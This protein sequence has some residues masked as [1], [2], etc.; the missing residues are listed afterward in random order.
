MEFSAIL[1]LALVNSLSSFSH[2]Y[3][4][5]SLNDLSILPQRNHQL[6]CFVLF[7]WQWIIFIV[8]TLIIQFPC[9][10]LMLKRHT[11]GNPPHRNGYL[12]RNRNSEE[13]NWCEHTQWRQPDKNNPA[14][15]ALLTVT[16][17][18][19]YSKEAPAVAEDLQVVTTLKV[20]TINIFQ[21]KR[22]SWHFPKFYQSPVTHN[23]A[24]SYKKHQNNSCL[25]NSAA[26]IFH[27]FMV[28][29]KPTPQK[30]M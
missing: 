10:S 28:A 9:K 23:C 17:R 25:H 21:L 27:T 14:Y 13:F 3:I 22:S 6:S 1:L 24:C 19:N 26:V 11:Q 12:G 15:Q 8:F 29:E 7:I 2:L 20:N 30:I 5:T 18:V 4:Y 16:D